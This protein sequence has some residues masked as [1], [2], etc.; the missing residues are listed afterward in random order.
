M[1]EIVSGTIIGGEI[2]LIAKREGWFDPL[3]H[4]LRRKHRVLVFGNTGAGKTQLIESLE[5]TAPKAIDAITRTAVVTRHRLK[6]ERKP[7]VFIDTPGEYRDKRLEAIR[8]AIKAPVDGVM[9]VVSYGYDE[10]HLGKDEAIVRGQINAEY[11]AKRRKRELEL[12]GEWAPDLIADSPGTWLITVVT[13]ADLW[14]EERDRVI[15]HYTKGPY[16]AR[17]RARTKDHAGPVLEYCSV[18][19]P[20]HGVIPPSPLFSEQDRELLRSHLL[21][22]IMA[23]IK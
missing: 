20:F 18:Y 22:T 21:K 15:K 5:K 12:I 17:L 9:N 19:R 6:I 11:L 8:E 1:T 7:F 10:G 16:H 14:W 3:L 23:A 13:K 4:A 2:A